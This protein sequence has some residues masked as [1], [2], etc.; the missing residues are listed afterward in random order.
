MTQHLSSWAYVQRREYLK[1][2]LPPNLNF[3]TTHNN[4][5]VQTACQSADK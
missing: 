5:E 1:E 4:L 2:T 3:N